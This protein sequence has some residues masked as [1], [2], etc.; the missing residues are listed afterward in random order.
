[1]DGDCVASSVKLLYLGILY[2]FIAGK[3]I[4][5]RNLCRFIKGIHKLEP[6]LSLHRRR[7]IF[8]VLFSIALLV[9]KIYPTKLYRFIPFFSS[10]I[11]YRYCFNRYIFEYR[12]PPME[13]DHHATL[14]P[15]IIQKEF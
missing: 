6:I 8:V 15:D 7:K 11:V 1:M 13:T 2:R 9:K 5:S 14:P 3:N 10:K 4:L 12:C